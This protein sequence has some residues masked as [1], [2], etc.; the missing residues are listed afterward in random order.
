MVRRRGNT[1]YYD[2]MVRGK[3]YREAIPDACTK[4]EAKD[5]EAEARRLVRQGKYVQSQPPKLETFIREV[6]LP[7]AE[8]NKRSY[9]NDV[10]RCAV[11]NEHF[12][13]LRLN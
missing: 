2:F 12:G 11:L 10:W 3:R 13:H 9:R 8:V 4:Q 6:Y 5:N 7:W 1:W